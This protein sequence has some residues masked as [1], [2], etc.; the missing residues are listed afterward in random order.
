MHS[1][2][3]VTPKEVQFHFEVNQSSHAQIRVQSLMHTI[4]VAYKVSQHHHTAEHG[5]AAVVKALLA[6]KC[7]VNDK[8]PDA[9]TPLFVAVLGGHYETVKMLLAEEKCCIHLPSSA[10]YKGQ[11]LA[12]VEQ[13]I[14]RLHAGTDFS[15]Q[16]PPL[17]GETKLW[18]DN[19]D[20][21]FKSSLKPML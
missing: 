6:S 16:A 20:D 15:K 3:M 4:P 7:D 5:N 2:I 13:Y 14:Q 21:E 9:H 1:L 19:D 8:D 10:A 18:E 11:S 12:H 17:L